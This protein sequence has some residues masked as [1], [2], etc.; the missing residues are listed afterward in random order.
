MSSECEYSVPMKQKSTAAIVAF[1]VRSL[2]ERADADAP[3][4]IPQPARSEFLEN[5]AQGDWAEV[6]LAQAIGNAGLAVTHYGASDDI[7][8]DEAGFAEFFK[9]QIR[10]VRA[11]GKRPDLLIRNA[12][13]SW[14]VS[15]SHLP[16]AQRD[17]FVAQAQASIEAGSSA[18]SYR[19]RMCRCSSIVRLRSTCGA[20]SS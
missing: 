10:D 1:N 11:F 17:P 2:R 15:V 8:S 9:A 6:L 7:Q 16:A 12:A 14:P 3:I 5:R 18:T 19:R 13:T 20:S 4:K